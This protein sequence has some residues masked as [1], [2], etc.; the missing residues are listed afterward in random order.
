MGAAAG[1]GLDAEGAAAAVAAAASGRACP[2]WLLQRRALDVVV[3]LRPDR[4]TNRGSSDLSSVVSHW[5][6]SELP[7]H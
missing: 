5:A 4:S 6:S 7:Q 3:V 1:T 2:A